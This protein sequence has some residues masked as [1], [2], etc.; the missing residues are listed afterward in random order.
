M[1]DLE[2]LAGRVEALSGPDREVDALIA[3]AVNADSMPGAIK[4]QAIPE[5]HR[6][7][8]VRHVFNGGAS[9]PEARKYTASI[10]AAMTLVDP[11]WW[12]SMS[13]PVSPAAH[14]YSREDQRDCRAGF[15]MLGAP[16]SAGAHVPS[17][18]GDPI[19]RFARALTAAALR[20]RSRTQGNPNG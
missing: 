7:G 1:A 19:G 2:E 17:G 14:G 11:A 13:G 5:L 4:G 10:D 6:L 20:A 16:Y 8:R 18:E 3:I 9:F 15:E 12:L